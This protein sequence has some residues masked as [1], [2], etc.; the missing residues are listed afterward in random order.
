[1]IISRYFEDLEW[2]QAWSCFRYC[3]NVATRMGFRSRDVLDFKNAAEFI[4]FPL[5]IFSLFYDI[6]GPSIEVKSSF[7]TI[8]ILVSY[9]IF[10]KR[11]D[12]ISFMNIGAKINVIGKIIK[13]SIP[14]TFLLLVFP[15]F[16][17]LIRQDFIVLTVT[18][19]LTWCK[20]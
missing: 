18:R 5:C 7:Y 16:N 3:W 15:K 19:T 20:N 8:T 13:K 2:I 14:I 17:S 11:L 12:K 6:Y 4:N 1:M 10:V 9:Y